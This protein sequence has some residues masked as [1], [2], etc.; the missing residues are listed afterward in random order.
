MTSRS[1]GPQALCTAVRA[2]AGRQKEWHEFNAQLREA[3]LE[4]SPSL[5]SCW[6]GRQLDLLLLA[7]SN[8]MVRGLC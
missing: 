2:R 6:A 3:T 5:V 4:T 7:L 8:K 1:L